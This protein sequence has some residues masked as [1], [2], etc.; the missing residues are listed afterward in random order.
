[1][2]TNRRPRC[3]E[4]TWRLSH[5]TTD[6]LTPC[7]VRRT[8]TTTP[9]SDLKSER[10]RHAFEALQHSFKPTHD[11]AWSCAFEKL[12]LVNTNLFLCLH[13]NNVDDLSRV[14]R[15]NEIPR[16]RLP[17]QTVP[18]IYYPSQASG[19]SRC[20]ALRIQ[21]I[22]DCNTRIFGG[23]EMVATSRNTPTVTLF[24]HSQTTH[25][26]IGARGDNVGS[27]RPCARSLCLFGV[28]S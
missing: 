28:A 22:D 21:P 6:F 24:A 7:A 1:M 5:L 19:C 4:I 23:R 3:T 9:T 16:S 25:S 11:D 27:L 15:T 14:R 8:A 2:E 18:T 17:V 10:R 12:I 13:C 20:K 26:P